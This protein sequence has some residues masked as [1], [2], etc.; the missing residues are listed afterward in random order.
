MFIV[1]HPVHNIRSILDRVNISPISLPIQAETLSNI[2]INQTWKRILSGDLIGF[3][4]KKEISDILAYRW[5]KAV[6][7]YLKNKNKFILVKYEDFIKDKG[8]SIE[9][10]AGHLNLKKKKDI[11][12]IKDFQF[13]PKG[14]YSDCDIKKIFSLSILSKIQDICRDGMNKVGYDVLS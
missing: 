9:D 14:K 10:I 11:Q 2:Q 1:R 6:D 7:I 5:C 12:Y 3:G 4:E 13:Q 8:K